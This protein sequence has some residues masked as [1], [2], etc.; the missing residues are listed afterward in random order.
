M[1][2]F[3]PT[4]LLRLGTKQREKRAALE[5]KSSVADGAV[6]QLP[7]RQVGQGIAEGERNQQHRGA[8]KS[9]AAARR[10]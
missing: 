5:G 10:Y 7:P 9:S 8:G 3:I 2:E 6:W 1:L 4:V